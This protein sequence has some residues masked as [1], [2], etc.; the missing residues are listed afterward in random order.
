MNSQLPVIPSIP[1]GE[2]VRYSEALT[3]YNLLLGM[4]A[5]GFIVISSLEVT[6]S[7]LDYVAGF[8]RVDSSI[9]ASIIFSQGV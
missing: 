8:Y 7:T 9:F 6:A 5:D 3:A 4:A 1:V 2:F